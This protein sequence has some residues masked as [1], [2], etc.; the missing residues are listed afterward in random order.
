MNTRKLLNPGTF[1]RAVGSLTDGFNERT[2]VSSCN[3]SFE[4]LFLELCFNDLTNNLTS[5][6]N[7]CLYLHQFTKGHLRLHVSCL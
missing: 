4:F 3:A 5:T 2:H 7:D 6:A 1:Y